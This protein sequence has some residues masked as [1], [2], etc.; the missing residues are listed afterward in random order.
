MATL[1]DVVVSGAHTLGEWFRGAGDFYRITGDRIWETWTESDEADEERKTTQNETA[2]PVVQPTP[3]APSGTGDDGGGTGVTVNVPK[4]SPN[5]TTTT[6]PKVVKPQQALIGAPAAGAGALVG[7]WK[8]VTTVAA[9]WAAFEAVRDIWE[10]F[11]TDPIASEEKETAF[12][13]GQ[14]LGHNYNPTTP[15]EIEWGQLVGQEEFDA[16]NQKAF[17]SYAL[18]LANQTGKLDDTN[19]DAQGSDFFEQA[20]LIWPG[21]TRDFGGGNHFLFGAKAVG[22]IFANYW[23]KSL[24]ATKIGLRGVTVPDAAIAPIKPSWIRDHSGGAGVETGD[25]NGGG[26][27]ESLSVII[28]AGAVANPTPPGTQPPPVQQP[29]VKLE[30]TNA[31]KVGA[32]GGLP[33]CQWPLDRGTVIGNQMAQNTVLDVV[34]NTQLVNVNAKLGPK[35]AGGISGW[36]GRF[37]KSIYLDKAINFLNILLNVHNATML[38]KNLVYTLGELQNIVINAIGKQMKNEVLEEFDVNEAVGK[39]FKGMIENILGKEQTEELSKKFAKYNRI[40]TSATNLLNSVES[41][42]FSLSEMM[43]LAGEYQGK[44]GNAL[45]RSGVILEDSYEAMQE[46]WRMLTGKR[47][48][49]IDAVLRGIDRGTEVADNLVGIAGEAVEIPDHLEELQEGRKAFTEAVKNSGP[50]RSPGN[51]PLTDKAAAEKTI[52]A[53][54]DI[55]SSDLVKPEE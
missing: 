11:Q 16:D 30:N 32:K 52:S 14:L 23:T 19:Y 54:P 46:K 15:T 48:A 13:F 31:N 20:V 12:K 18:W 41:I 2:K 55:S 44:V 28:A 49:K 26:L 5:P 21:D 50:E 43:S 27:A 51:K 40:V 1:I 38:S 22:D 25:P 33:M 9:G 10:G 34:T 47:F 37:A 8:F 4:T 17:N 29:K 42:L 53:S 3:Y 45:K 36:L 35:V 7:V 24:N 39:A 6:P